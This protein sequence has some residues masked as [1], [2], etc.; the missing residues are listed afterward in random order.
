MSEQN[1][2]SIEMPMETSVGSQA[3]PNDGQTIATA[4]E[5]TASGS[6]GNLHLVTCQQILMSTLL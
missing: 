2:E 3:I 1:I 4:G 6:S 5:N